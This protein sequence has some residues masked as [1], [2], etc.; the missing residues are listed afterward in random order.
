MDMVCNVA[1]VRARVAAWRRAG[2][3]VALVPTMGNLH[4]GHMSLVRAAQRE[5]D[6]TVV[7]IFVNP[8]QFAPSEDFDAY[9]R[10]LEA[11]AALLRANAADLLFAPSVDEMYPLGPNT[12]WVEVE[13]LGRYLCG[14]NR[15]T[16][17]RGVTTVVSK[18][19]LIVAPDVAVFGEK[20]FQ[21]LTILR[22]MTAELRFPIRI[23]GVPTWREA[24]G[25][26]FSSRNGYLTEAERERAPL[27]QQQ[28]QQLKR[29]IADGER[30]YRALEDV[31]SAALAAQGFKVDY[32]SVADAETLAPATSE[33][34]KLVIAAAA[35]LGKPRLID[36]VT[37]DLT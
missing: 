13:Q 6:V 22:R 30:D 35:Y 2:K 16:H 9:P 17:F 21:Q 1:E 28:L 27:I 25:L 37:L 7:S 18:L 24:D 8:T 34:R 3:T 10:T 5:A 31:M 20:D 23:V 26:A 14:A 32:V 11:D 33:D 12:T 19:F 29:A 15:P 36:N 4:A